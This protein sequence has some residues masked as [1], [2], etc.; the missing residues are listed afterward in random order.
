MRNKKI[1]LINPNTIILFFLIYLIPMIINFLQTGA[2]L[3]GNKYQTEIAYI[4]NIKELFNHLRTC[5]E[6]S[7]P[8]DLTR[9][10][11]EFFNGTG[12]GAKACPFCAKPTSN[13][14]SHLMKCEQRRKAQDKRSAGGVPGLFDGKENNTTL[15]PA[16]KSSVVT[17]CHLYGL[18]P[19]IDS[20]L[21]LVLKT[22]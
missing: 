15:L 4:E 11:G 14:S 1:Y 5:V 9:G 2:N 19:P 6:E 10:A 20:S 8:E 13:L 17:S 3:N 16:N 21:T 12:Q 22:T 7:L 18:S